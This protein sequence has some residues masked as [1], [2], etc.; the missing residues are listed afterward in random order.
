MRFPST[1]TFASVIALGALSAP[2][3]ADVTPAQLLSEWQ[4]FFAE[5]EQVLEFDSREEI[6]GGLRITDMGTSI[7]IEGGGKLRISAPEVLLTE[8]GDGQVQIELPSDILMMVQGDDG[9]VLAGRF[10]HDAL[11]L[12]AGGDDAERS[13]FYNALRAEF[14]IDELTDDDGEMVPVEVSIVMDDINTEYLSSEALVSSAYSIG[15]LDV[16]VAAENPDA[17]GMEENF[18]LTYRMT[19]IEGEGAADPR[20]MFE[21]GDP[22]ELLEAGATYGGTMVHTGTGYTF[23][24]KSDEANA[25]V[26]GSS[27]G[28]A[29]SASIGPE[30]LAYEIAGQ[31]TKLR[32][33]G[34]QLPFPVE[35]ALDS[36]GFDFAVPL[37]DDPEPQPFGFLLALGGLEVSQG[38]WN[39]FDPA[40]V[41]P[42]DASELLIDLTGTMTI[43]ESLTAM[44]PTNGPPPAEVDTLNLNGLLL[45][46]AG[47]QLSGQGGF[48]LDFSKP[49]LAPGAPSAVGELELELLGANKLIDRLVQIGILQPQDVTGIRMMM[50]MAARPGDEPD[51]LVSKI[52]LTPNGG[53]VANGMP[54][55]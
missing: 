7:P 27:A 31:E 49:G 54:L 25:I 29:F 26:D 8:L 37:L 22:T 48:E 51:S 32:Y 35:I 28:G 34:D 42:R 43:L 33:Q 15:A 30:G 55:R 45:A 39:L 52:E 6:D 19:G 3:L 44:D 11:E 47:A 46:I 23:D 38:V 9:Q 12:I 21:Y 14:L 4:S 24:L 10:V 20:L 5:A 17:D 41:L 36:F 50:G 53:L 2:A 1:T 40:E 13:V 18:S 16:Q